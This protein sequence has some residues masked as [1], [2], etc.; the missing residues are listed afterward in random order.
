MSASGLQIMLSRVL[1]VP[2]DRV[3]VIQCYTGGSFGSKVVLNAIYPASAV[4]SRITGHPVKMVYT[5]EEEYF[6]SRPRFAGRY[7]VKTAVRKDG[8]ILGRELSFYYD[9]GAYCDMAA[10]MIIVCSHRN[11]N[12]YRIPAIRTD[13]KLVYTNK[14]PRGRLSGLW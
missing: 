1:K 2:A 5:R 11:D 14:N 12:V 8:T 4:L 7:Y 10:A 3:R 13:A 9:A 6:A